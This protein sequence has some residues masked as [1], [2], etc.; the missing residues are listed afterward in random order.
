MSENATAEKA[1]AE[2]IGQQYSGA[3]SAASSSE[4]D[5]GTTGKFSEDDG[6]DEEFQTKIACLT[7]RDSEFIRKVGHLITPDYFENA[8]EAVLVNNA[9]TFYRKYGELPQREAAVAILKAGI[10]S[11]TIRGDLRDV[12]VEKFRSIYARSPDL[13]NA[14][15]FAQRI[16]D[17]AR[18]QAVSRAI[19][20]SVDMIGRKQFDKIEQSIKAAVNIAIN[21]DGDEYD[22]FDRIEDRTQERADRA[23]GVIL[24][25]GITTGHRKMDDLLYHSGWGRKEL[26]VILGGPKSGKTTA[27]IN[28][29]K[30]ASLD[31]KN[32]LY[33]TLEVSA[34]I[35]SERLDASISDTMIRELMSHMHDVK[36]KIQAMKA[37]SGALQIHEYPSGTFTPDMLRRLIERYKSPTLRPDGTVREPIKFDLICVDYMDIM[38]PDNY[39]DS[40]IEN[41][42][43]VGLALRAIAQTEDAA[44]LSATQGNREGAQATVMKATHVADDYNKVRTVDLLISINITDEERA[45]GECRLYFAASR[46]QEGGFTLFIKQELAKM[47]FIASIV[48]VE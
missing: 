24:P 33:V 20:A 21:V 2:L 6:F 30:A 13:S 14:D 11:K 12:T 4:V 5:A 36:S 7:V 8:S 40:P 43:S 9:L 16:A 42:K 47:K 34:K 10:K 19:Y 18:H 44:M 22:Y 35:I 41:S 38:A 17:F 32:V 1:V 26:A 39:T 48:R 45:A 28:F 46:N 25:S 23:A 29:A 37:R 31:G 27:L 3:A 15:Y